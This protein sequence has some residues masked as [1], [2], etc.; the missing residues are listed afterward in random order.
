M[1]EPD[2][3]DFIALQGLSVGT[4]TRVPDS[5]PKD[6][7]ISQSLDATGMQ[8]NLVLS[9][10]N[11]IVPSVLGFFEADARTA[12]LNADLVVGTVSYHDDCASPGEVETQYPL[13]QT[14]V[15]RLT[16]VNITVSTCVPGGPG[17][18]IPK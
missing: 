2:A 12:I 14:S 1:T 18:G 15:N 7:V 3:R 10:G 9:D 5:A 6:T 8:V 13:W 16:P 4:V 11:R 17:G